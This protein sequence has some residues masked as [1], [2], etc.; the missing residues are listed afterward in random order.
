MSRLQL[1]PQRKSGR[2]VVSSGC[3][4]VAASISALVVL[5]VLG[6]QARAD[7]PH[8]GVIE[9][10][11]SCMPCHGVE[12]RGDGRRARSLKTAPAD[13]TQIAKF[14]GGD[15]PSAQ[16]A[17]IIDGRTIIAAHGQ[18]EM[19][20]WGDRYRRPIEANEPVAAIERRAQAQITALVR[21]LETIQAK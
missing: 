1:I 7:D 15:F 5:F 21:Y 9:Y 18:R 10:E 13:L 12:G 16:V 11:I 8:L 20:V 2:F 3:R 4:S 6:G 19:P 17:E 14:H